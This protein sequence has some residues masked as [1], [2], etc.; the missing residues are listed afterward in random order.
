MIEVTIAATRVRVFRLGDRRLFFRHCKDPFGVH[1]ALE[2]EYHAIDPRS[3]TFALRDIRTLK[4]AF[5][6]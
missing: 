1:R 6:A 2:S 5:D 3:G 4:Q